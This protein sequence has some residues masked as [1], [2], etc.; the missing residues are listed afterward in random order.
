MRLVFTEQA[1]QRMNDSFQFLLEKQGVPSQK[2]DQFR[3]NIRLSIRQ[4]LK[5]PY[6]GERETR[7]QYL[8]KE[9]RRLIEGYFKI[10]YFILNDSIYITDIFDS[11]QDPDKMKG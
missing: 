1:Q 11:R 10:I 9:H 2:I 5:N 7:L 6:Q 3:D 4:L 8:N